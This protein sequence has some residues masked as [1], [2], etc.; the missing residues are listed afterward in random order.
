MH[1][2]LTRSTQLVEILNN[3]GH[4]LSN[5]VIQEVETSVPERQIPQLLT[6]MFTFHPKYSHMC[7]FS[8][9]S[10]NKSCG[11]IA[12][13]VCDNDID[14]KCTHVCLYQWMLGEFITYCDYKYSKKLYVYPILSWIMIKMWYLKIKNLTQKN[15]IDFEWFKLNYVGAHFVMTT[16]AFG[17]HW[18]E[19]H[20]ISSFC[21][22][23]VKLTFSPTPP[24]QT[25]LLR[26]P[27]QAV[28]ITTSE[29]IISYNLRTHCNHQTKV[30]RGVQRKCT[31]LIWAH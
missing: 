16:W 24:S 15:I 20:L 29:N 11:E 10:L 4:S 14:N 6:D 8:W 5:S 30:P 25:A 23:S 28:T 19:K 21:Y 7:L 22:K 2:R 3:F 9:P 31:I 18:M 17:V 27:C 1:N 26:S 12:L 13:S